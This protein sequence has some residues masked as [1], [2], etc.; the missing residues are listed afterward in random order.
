[1]VRDL[2]VSFYV[3]YSQ[4]EASE[5]LASSIENIES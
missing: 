2:V 4:Q 1:M 5:L 3:S